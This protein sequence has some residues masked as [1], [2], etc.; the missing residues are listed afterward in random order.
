MTARHAEKAQLG[1]PLTRDDVHRDFDRA[2]GL[3]DEG[4]PGGRLPDR[5][6]GARDQDL[7]AVPAR[8]LDDRTQRLDRDFG[9][10]SD[11]AGARDVGP[12][13]RLFNVVA[14]VLELPSHYIGYKGVHRVASDVDRR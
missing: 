10:G 8:A 6:R 2:A 11:G 13:L 1:L 7:E 12:Q 4:V 5:L 9:P 3:A 14:D